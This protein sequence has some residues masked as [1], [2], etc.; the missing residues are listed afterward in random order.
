MNITTTFDNPP[1]PI[2]GMDWSAIDADTYDPETNI[3]GRGR[4]EIDAINNLV[5]QLLEHAAEQDV[6]GARW[7]W[8][9]EQI[10]DDRNRVLAQALLWNTNSRSELDKQVDQARLQKEKQT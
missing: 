8:F 5:E 4:R 1:I 9:R 10:K 2:R 3:I 7:R 6:D